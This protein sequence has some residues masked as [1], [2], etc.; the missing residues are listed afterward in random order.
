MYLSSG[1]CNCKISGFLSA[2]Q[3]QRL[4]SPRLAS[5]VNGFLQR[6]TTARLDGRTP[7]ETRLGKSEM[8]KAIRPLHL[9]FFAARVGLCIPAT[10]TTSRCPALSKSRKRYISNPQGAAQTIGATSHTVMKPLNLVFVQP[11]GD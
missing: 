4:Q 8:A 5:P 11:L 9:I 7:D 10:L 6:A 1:C 2:R 3:R